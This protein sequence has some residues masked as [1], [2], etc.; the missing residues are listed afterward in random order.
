M[1][2]SY[3]H[4]GVFEIFV[5]FACF[6]FREVTIINVYNLEADSQEEDYDGRL[7]RL[8]LLAATL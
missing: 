6:D 8:L 5:S 1:L 4:F 3:S 2:S 7:R